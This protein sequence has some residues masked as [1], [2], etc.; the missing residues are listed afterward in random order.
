MSV[1]PRTAPLGQSRQLEMMKDATT[2]PYAETEQGPLHVHLFRSEHDVGSEPG[3]TVLFFHGGFWDHPMSTQFVPQCLH[4]A[5]R[6]AVA[7]AVE[8]RVSS[9]HGTGPVEALEDLHKLA[10]WLPTAGDRGVDPDRLILAGSSG[11]AWLA[12]QAVLPKKER[13]PL[14]AQ[15]LILFSPLLNTRLPSISPRFPDGRTLRRLNPL[16]QVRRR[17]PPMLI[18]HGKSDRLTPYEDAVRF[19]RALKWRRN[20]VQLLDFEKAEHSFFNFNVSELHYELTLQAADR[21]LVEMGLLEP[22][23]PLD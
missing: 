23:V 8:T 22:E 6:G 20:R 17:L 14:D 9:I 21:F 16:R 5:A 15:G 18:C 19:A 7:L 13:P 12:L 2:V 1:L 4:L 10:S 3:P 11:G